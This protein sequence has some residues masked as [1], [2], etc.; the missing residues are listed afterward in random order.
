[1]LISGRKQNDVNPVTMSGSMCCCM[2]SRMGSGMCWR[3]RL[4]MCGACC[5]VCISASRRP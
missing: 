2:G 4:N 3:M 1:M 5:R